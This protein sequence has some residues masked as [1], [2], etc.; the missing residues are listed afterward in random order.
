MSYSSFG[1]AEGGNV[2][3]C[4]PAGATLRTCGGG[5]AGTGAPPADATAPGGGDGGGESLF[6]ATVARSSGAPA[7]RPPG[8]PTGPLSRPC[9]GAAI[10]AWLPR[11]RG[12]PGALGCCDGSKTS[13]RRP[14]LVGGPPGAL[15]GFI[16]T[17]CAG[18]GALPFDPSCWNRY[19]VSSCI[20]LS[21]ISSC[22]LRY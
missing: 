6:P 11:T 4:W 15:P 17:A 18:G 3:S 13:E 10:A 16:G 20:R 5:V 19:S 8:A 21:C 9:S 14:G 22:W 1:E 12:A 7:A 2:A